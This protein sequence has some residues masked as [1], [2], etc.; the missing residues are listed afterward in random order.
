[1]MQTEIINLITDDLIIKGKI[2]L[3]NNLPYQISN[4]IYTFGDNE[5][6]TILAFIDISDNLDGSSGIIFTN[7][8]LYSN[9]GSFDYDEIIK[10]ELEKH[11]DSNIAAIFITT[12]NNK[13][14]FN[15]NYF[16]CEKLI[17]LLSKISNTKIEM[18]LTEHEKI[19]YLIKV[20]LDDILNDEYEDVIL[21]S[22]QEKTINEFLDNLKLIDKLSNADYNYELENLCTQAINLFDELE[23]D[24]E[25]IDELINI[26]DKLNE[27]NTQS[28]N[29]EEYYDD[30]MN[31]YL[32]GDQDT[33]NQMK[34]IMQS[35]GLDEEA[36]KNKSPDEINQYIDDLCNRFGI[37]RSQVENLA[38]RFNFRQ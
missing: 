36:L 35:L 24:S 4:A 30:L 13:L 3:E 6:T 14:S 19:A 7:N 23:L 9:L 37:S 22:Q 38:K 25:E 16:N 34:G 5:I 15:N 2:Y 17:E 11:H 26:Q 21:T 28:S 12:K 10:L 27:K 29:N 8:K 18:I 33:L 31:K 32:H 1:M 20:V